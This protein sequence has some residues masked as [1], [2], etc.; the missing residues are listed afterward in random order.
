MK[1]GNLVVL[2]TFNGMTTPLDGVRSHENYWKLIGCSGEILDEK[3]P[4]FLPCS[5]T[6]SKRVL[7]RFD[8]NL[9]SLGLANHNEVKNTLWM[10]TSDLQL[11]K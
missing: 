1:N 4:K 7:V 10:L 11:L 6:E 2:K 5:P 3:H 9:D 8:T